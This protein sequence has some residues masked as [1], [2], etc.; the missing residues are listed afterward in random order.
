MVSEERRQ[1]VAAT[2]KGF[3]CKNSAL[4]GEQVCRVHLKVSQQRKAQREK[5][6][7]LSKQIAT[8]TRG[9]RG[10]TRLS[11]NIVKLTISGKDSKINGHANQRADHTHGNI[12]IFTYAHMMHPKPTKTPYLHLAEPTDTKWIDY[13]RTAPFNPTDKILI[14]VGYTRKSPEARVQEWREQCGHS[15]FVLL[16]PGC[17]VPLYGVKGSNGSKGTRAITG[18]SVL[19]HAEKDEQKINMIAKLLQKMHLKGD[20]QRH[21]ERQNISTD[22]LHRNWHRHAPQHRDNRLHTGR[23]YAYLNSARTCFL[24]ANPYQ[25]EQKI[26]KLLRERYGSGKMYC[27][28]CAKL[29]LNANHHQ[30]VTT[31]VHTEWFLVPRT[32]MGVVWALIESQCC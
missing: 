24:T 5:D 11:S 8:A 12:Y 19:A 3:Q 18:V 1:C 6:K 20:E 22:S 32:E 7:E 27:D 23:N 28:G 2:K 16:Y 10:G 17:L 26:H 13:S 25:V 30:V 31:G 21:Q 4:K 15:E 14:K 29:R 9:R